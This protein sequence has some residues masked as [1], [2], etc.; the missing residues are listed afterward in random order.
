MGAC[1]PSEARPDPAS[2]N[3]ATD[4]RCGLAAAR[5]SIF[6]LDVTNADFTLSRFTFRTSPLDRQHLPEDAS[7]RIS[8]W[9]GC[10][11]VSGRYLVFKKPEGPRGLHSIEIKLAAIRRSQ[12][13]QYTKIR[14]VF[15][16]VPGHQV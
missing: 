15:G 9:T 1:R 16:Y 5:T 4:T 14:E 3:A 2:R 12:R 11:A 8:P 6:T 7:S 13:R 10:A